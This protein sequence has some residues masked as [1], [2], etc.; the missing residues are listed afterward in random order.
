M[1]NEELVDALKQMIVDDLGERI[2]ILLN[3][4]Y[5]VLDRRKNMSDNTRDTQFKGFAKSLI[6]ELDVVSTTTYASFDKAQEAYE[7]VIV[8]RAYDLVKHTIKN[9]DIVDLDRL[10]LDE[11]VERI[12]DMI[13]LPKE[14]S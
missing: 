1:I 4:G 3:E 14:S 10:T 7:L 8:R 2:H 9:T 6:R 12:P 5:E 11:H 13:E